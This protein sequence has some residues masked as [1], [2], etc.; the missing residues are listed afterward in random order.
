MSGKRLLS[1]V[2]PKRGEV[3]GGWR[4]LHNYEYYNFYSSLSK[5]R[6]TKSRRMVFGG[7]VA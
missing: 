1:I 6:V 2:G 5:I 4:K 3:K 7:H